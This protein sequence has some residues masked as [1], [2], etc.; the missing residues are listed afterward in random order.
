MTNLSI[1]PRIA[2]V[3]LLLSGCTGIVGARNGTG[4]STGTAG[5]DPT[6]VDPGNGTPGTGN[7]GGGN[8]TGPVGTID[9][10]TPTADSVGP[11]WQRRLTKTEIGNSVEA[12]TGVRPAAL[13]D[14]PD[15]AIDYDF[16]RV[17]QSQTV[18]DRHLQAYLN[19]GDQVVAAL[20][21][22]KIGS[23]APNCTTLNRTCAQSVIDN[24]GRRAFRGPVDPDQKTLMLALFDGGATPRE[25]IDQI[26]RFLLQ[27]PSFIYVIERGTAVAGQ[28]GTYALNDYEI[29]TRLSMLACETVPDDALLTAAAAGQVHQPDQIAAQ[30][31]RLFAQPCAHQVT[32]R[33][34]TQWLKLDRMA[35]IM[36]D[37]TA[38]PQFTADV[39]AAM[40]Q[41]D[42]LFLEDLVWTSAAPLSG[43]FTATASFIDK[44]LGPIYGISGL[45]STPTKVMLPAERM[46]ILTH[47]SVLTTLSNPAA[48]SP[49]RRGG[50]VYRKILCQDIAPP[51]PTAGLDTSPPKD[52]PTLTTR[53]RYELRTGSGVCGGCHSLFNPIGFTM[54][55]FDPIGRV[56]T[57]DNNLPIDASG[58]I[59]SFGVQGLD[60]GASLAAALAE[61]DEMRLC[62]GRKWLRYGL[63]RSE[64]QADAT[65]IRA[66]VDKTRQNATI[67]D[68]MVSLT[69][70]YAFT[71]RAEAVDTGVMP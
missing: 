15:E 7:A 70:T 60:G 44:R 47:P 18:A 21:D 40:V 35:T 34:F 17:T 51:P 52:D 2:I 48:T 65:S 19:I 46:G 38:F 31:T 33:F 59:P 9:I 20:T 32:G 27:S 61:N 55:N 42:Q 53:Q 12:L 13:A 49:V 8:V 22:A 23:L 11:A 45:G 41:E 39:R 69:Q 58:G 56:R 54:E 4:A 37:T 30:T 26:I 16:D 36:P 62:F 5:N 67:R 66:V 71:H 1:R 6:G 63:G 50:Y 43:L 68:A 10:E 57:T 14:L 29:A 25:G 28:P 3:A 64:T 24:L